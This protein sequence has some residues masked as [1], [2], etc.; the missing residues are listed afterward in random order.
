MNMQQIGITTLA[1]FG[2]IGCSSV[3]TARSMAGG[4][5]KTVAVGLGGAVLVND[6][7][8]PIWIMTVDGER[9]GVPSHGQYLLPPGPHTVRVGYFWSRGYMT[10]TGNELADYSFEAKAGTTL[11]VMYQY[12]EE[13]DYKGTWRFWIADASNGEAVPDSGPILTRGA[14]G[15]RTEPYFRRRF[16]SG[17]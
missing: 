10:W 11:R 14:T 3:Y 16:H 5:P 6:D 8:S 4:P 15:E 13:P 1:V 2:F 17:P 12:T 7:K 9:K